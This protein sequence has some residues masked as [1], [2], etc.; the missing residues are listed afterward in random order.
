MWRLGLLPGLVFAG[1][2]LWRDCRPA[3]TSIPPFCRA[4]GYVAKLQLPEKRHSAVS[5]DFACVVSVDA[6][7]VTFSVTGEGCFDNNADFMTD[8][9]MS[10]ETPCVIPDGEWVVST[11][12]GSQRIRVVDGGVDCAP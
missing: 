7:V 1:C 5:D 12:R 9:P 11:N 3:E 8:T 10:F 2:G 4:E 6:G